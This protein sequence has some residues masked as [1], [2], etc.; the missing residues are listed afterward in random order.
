MERQR[1]WH[2]G[3]FPPY[4]PNIERL[5]CHKTSLP[6]SPTIPQHPLLPLSRAPLPQPKVLY[7]TLSWRPPHPLTSHPRSY[8]WPPNPPGPH[9]L[10]SWSTIQTS[11]AS[12][13]VIKVKRCNNPKGQLQPVCLFPF[14]PT[15]ISSDL[16]MYCY[17]KGKVEKKKNKF[18]WNSKVKPQALGPREA[19]LPIRQ[20]DEKFTDVF[21]H[22]LWVFV[23]KNEDT[24]FCVDFWSAEHTPWS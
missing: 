6:S 9:C 12:D 4:W 23:K 1:A 13:Q 2:W 5:L 16:L 22:L 21:L 11:S 7:H 8:L 18:L 20:T 10:T 17:I 24:I 3:L 19:P 15:Y 14:P